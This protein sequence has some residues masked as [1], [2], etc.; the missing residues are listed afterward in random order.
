[1][2]KPDTQAM[3]STVNVNTFCILW[4]EYGFPHLT[5]VSQ[6]SHSVQLHSLAQPYN[7]K[8]KGKA[9]TT[10]QNYDEYL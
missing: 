1:M 5:K 10:P 9:K 4:L 7:L 2:L 3:C 6:S 8:K